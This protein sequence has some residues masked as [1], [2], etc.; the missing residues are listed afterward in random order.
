MTLESVPAALEEM[1]YCMCSVHVQCGGLYDAE[2][3]ET[4][5]KLVGW[6]A[7]LAWNGIVYGLKAEGSREQRLLGSSMQRWSTT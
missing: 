7:M 2:D 5:S 4:G 3:R 6:S 1:Y